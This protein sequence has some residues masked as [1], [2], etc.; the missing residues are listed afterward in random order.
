[1]H[2]IIVQPSEDG[3]LLRRPG[4]PSEWFDSVE[5]ASIA[6]E[7]LAHEFHACFGR[8]ACVVVRATGGETVLRRFGDPLPA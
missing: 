8:A 2:R 3:W 5:W 6:A 7:S 4:W 1:M